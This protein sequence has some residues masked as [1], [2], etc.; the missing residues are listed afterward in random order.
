VTLRRVIGSKKDQYFLDKKMT[1]YV[2]TLSVSR[3]CFECSFVDGRRSEMMS[4]DT[5]KE[6]STGRVQCPAQHI[7]CYFRDSKLI[8]VKG[9]LYGEWCSNSSEFL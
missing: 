6:L 5:F 2:I 4:A 9:R 7:A 1:T 8:A 3:D